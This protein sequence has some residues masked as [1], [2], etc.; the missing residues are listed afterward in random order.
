MNRRSYKATFLFLALA[1]TF[2]L[3]RMF[4]VH[5]V[6]IQGSS[7]DNTL[8][9][10]EI[11]LVTGFDYRF[12]GKPERGDIVECAFPNRSGTYV[13][14]VIGLPGETVEIVP[15]A[16]RINGEALEQDVTPAWLSRPHPPI[17]LGEDEYYVL[18]DNRRNSRDSRSV[19]P[20]RRRDITGRAVCILWPLRR[21]G[22]IR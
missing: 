16:V 3:L 5:T 14:R 12:G 17:T 18:G 2:V 7:M 19:G 6:R 22:K 20:V 11:A 15:G 21:I 4:V 10:G 1:V 9:D 13:K 8:R